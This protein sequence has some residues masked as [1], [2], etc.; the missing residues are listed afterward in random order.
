MRVTVDDLQHVVDVLRRYDDLIDRA[1]DEDHR[2]TI[3]L[4]VRDA[5]HLAQIAGELEK[6]PEHD[7]LDGVHQRAVSLEL[8]AFTIRFFT[9]ELVSPVAPVIDGILR[10]FMPEAS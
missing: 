2:Q 10:G 8:D 5:H 1:L 6:E 4:R 7:I 9:V 3:D